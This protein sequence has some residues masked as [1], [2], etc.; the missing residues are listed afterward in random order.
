[1]TK[2][3]MVHD[4]AGAHA[5]VVSVEATKHTTTCSAG[6]SFFGLPLHALLQSSLWPLQVISLALKTTDTL[7]ALDLSPPNDRGG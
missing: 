3:G 4:E 6:P 2:L 7:Q 5:L 1:M